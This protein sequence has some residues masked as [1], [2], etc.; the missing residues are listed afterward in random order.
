[1][2]GWPKYGRWT[3][4]YLLAVA[5]L[6]AV[7]VRA[8]DTVTVG[9]TG[10]TNAGIGKAVYMAAES[11]QKSHPSAKFEF[12]DGINQA[13]ATTLV[14][15]GQ[16]I[17]LMV[18]NGD[19]VASLALKGV[20]V[21]L[22]QQAAKAGLRFDTFYPP[23]LPQATIDGRIYGVPL[24][25]NA[26]FALWWNVDTVASIGAHTD[27]APDTMADLLAVHRK[28]TSVGSD[29]APVRIGLVPWQTGHRA[30]AIHFYGAF[31]GGRYYDTQSG[32]FLV[33]D[34]GATRALEWMLEFVRDY[35]KAQLD[36][37]F[38]GGVESGRVG[39]NVS[40]SQKLLQAVESN[41][42]VQFAVDLFPQASPGGPRGEFLAGPVMA[43]PQTAQADNSL[44]WQFLR[45]LTTTNDG[46]QII[47][48]AGLFPAKRDAAV[49]Q[50]WARDPYRA[51]Y[52]RIAQMARGHRPAFLDPDIVTRTL[53]AQVDAALA[54]QLPAKQALDEANR[55]LEQY[56]S[57]LLAG[58]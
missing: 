12:I 31:Y 7:P 25:V 53:N 9:V 47:A 15:G 39:Y 45:Y 42:S 51:P 20:V 11:H 30:N 24:F 34:D 17:D 16:P 22:D 36:R 57:E 50:A 8:A 35:P 37:L 41:P 21:P 44:A 13:K 49:L 19:W 40:V 58:K 2:A 54:G 28:L 55:Q 6:A 48:S 29:G 18:V 14:A 10:G 33:N 27:R 43:V 52:V 4:I 1:M 5:L 32:R 26:H 56:Y 3:A 38:S 23:L 46:V